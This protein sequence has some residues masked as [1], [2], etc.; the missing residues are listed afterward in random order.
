MKKFILPLFVVCIFA[1]GF[2][3]SCVFVKKT[4]QNPIE[5]LSSGLRYN[6]S[7]GLV[8]LYYIAAGAGGKIYTTTD[9]LNMAWTERNIATLN[10]INYLKNTIRIDTAVTFGVGDNGTVI[11]SLDQGITWSVLN[12]S[13]TENLNS[14]DF[15][16]SGLNDLIAVGESGLII[17]STNGGD[18]WSIINSGVTKNL[19]SVFSLNSFTNF[20]VG[21]DG[22]LLR[23]SNGGLNWENRSLNDTATDL[24]KIGLMGTWFFGDILGIIG[25]NGKLYRSTN[26][27]SWDSIPTSTNADL[28]DLQ[29]RSASSGYV[30]GSNGTV[31]YTLD[32]G[33]EWF[34]DFFIQSITDQRINSTI[35]INDTAVIGVAGNDIILVHA[36]ETLLPVELTSFTS[37]VSRNNVLLRWTTGNEINNLG[38]YIERRY[39]GEDWI[40]AG[41]VNGNGT[42]SEP[43]SYEFTDKNLKSGKYSYRLKQTDYNGNYEYFN[44]TNEIN[45]GAPEKFKLLQNYPNPFN[46][47]TKIAFELPYESEIKLSVYDIAGKEVAVLINRKLQAGFYEQQ[48]DASGFSSGIYFYRMYSNNGI[49]ESSDVRKMILVR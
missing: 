27:F 35:I 3:G 18:N 20:I 19:N 36:D 44:L 45:I 43:V 30:C 29:F 22:T 46:P 47:S 10:T 28:Y 42:T 49:S 37:S 9:P 38:F 12:S 6:G 2:R 17:K 8:D 21:D 31:L 14:I 23:S 13:V 39:G 40:N 5:T 41:F 24:N 11:R 34:S 7:E 15:I 1:A 16:G 32:G 48:W 25:D 33:N 4:H 26:Y